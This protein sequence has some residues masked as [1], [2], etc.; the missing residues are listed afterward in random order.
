MPK[1]K[2]LIRPKTCILLPRV[3]WKNYIIKGER[4]GCLSKSISLDTI[5][6]P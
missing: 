1:D 3:S 2:R 6:E 5:I 4:W